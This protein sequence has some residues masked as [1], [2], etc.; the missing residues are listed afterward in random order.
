MIQLYIP[1]H[2]NLIVYSKQLLEDLSRHEGIVSTGFF[3]K[4]LH[5]EFHVLADR[6]LVDGT[7]TSL[8]ML[9][10]FLDT[11]LTR[12]QQSCR[13]CAWLFSSFRMS[14]KTSGKT[15]NVSGLVLRSV[16]FLFFLFPFWNYF[17][18]GI[19]IWFFGVGIDAFSVLI[20]FQKKMKIL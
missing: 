14:F 13:T 15:Y 9:A 1:I 19:S 5:L 4:R 12:L 3:K 11:T 2:F 8:L 16:K 18:N 10:F 6:P 17:S 7:Y 20:H